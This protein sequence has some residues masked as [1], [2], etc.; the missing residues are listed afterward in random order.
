MRWTIS[1]SSWARLVSNQK[2][3]LGHHKF[4]IPISLLQ[5]GVCT[6]NFCWPSPV[7]APSA[8]VRP[9]WSYHSHFPLPLVTWPS[10]RSS[11][12]T[13]T[14]PSCA[15]RRAFLTQIA[16][17]QI[18]M[19]LASRD[20]HGRNAAERPVGFNW[21]KVAAAP[22]PDSHVHQPARLRVLLRVDHALR[23]HFRSRLRVFVLHKL[24]CTICE[25]LY[26]LCFSLAANSNIV[27]I[28]LG[29]CLTTEWRTTALIIVDLA[30]SCGYVAFSGIIHNFIIAIG[31]HS[32]R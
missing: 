19:L 25:N 8:R 16:D 32:K 12:N 3:E 7:R 11:C 15:V 22:D 17:L 21:P 9:S 26:F 6:T 14:C 29:E 5:A 31:A 30:G 20:V 28:F 1:K 13:S 27:R 4:K 10:P 2:P 23:R 18:Y 24:Q